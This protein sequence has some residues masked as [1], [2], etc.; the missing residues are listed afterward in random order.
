MLR[1]GICASFGNWLLAFWEISVLVSTRAAPVYIPTPLT[2]NKDSLLPRILVG[3]FPLII[4]WYR[5]LQVPCTQS[6]A[7]CLSSYVHLSCW[8]RGPCYLSVLSLWILLFFCLLFLR[9]LEP[10]GE[11]SDE[12]SHLGLNIPWSLTLCIISDWESLYFFFYHL[13]KMG[14]SLMMVE[15]VTDPNKAGRHSESFCC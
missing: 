11:G 4:A 3:I 15:Q 14:A 2:L 9:V 7:P 6:Q 13:L 10:W 1:S 8:F 12:T 5:P